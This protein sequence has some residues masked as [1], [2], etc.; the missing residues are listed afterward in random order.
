MF[1][2]NPPFFSILMSHLLPQNDI[3]DVSAGKVDAGV[4]AA[5]SPWRLDRLQ[6]SSSRLRAS[7]ADNPPLHCRCEADTALTYE[8]PSAPTKRRHHGQ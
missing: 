2:A 5:P 7:S 8:P 3:S 1:G 6:T 4:C